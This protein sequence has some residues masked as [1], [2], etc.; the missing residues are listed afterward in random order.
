MKALKYL[1]K[2]FYKYKWRL[3]TGFAFVIISNLFAIYP[4]Q[5]VRNVIDLISKTQK[6]HLNSN[7]EDLMGLIE[8]DLFYFFLTLIAFAILKGIFLFFKIAKA[9]RVR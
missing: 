3:L 1:N 5:I 4:A 8:K 9:I 7:P 2:Y 6:E